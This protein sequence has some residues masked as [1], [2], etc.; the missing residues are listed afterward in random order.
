MFVCSEVVVVLPVMPV[1]ARGPLEGVVMEQLAAWLAAE[2]YSRTMVPQV[3]G[4]AR[5]LSAWMDDH[6][7]S[8]AALSLDVLEAFQAKYAPGVP[9]HVIVKVR[10]PAVRRFLVECGYLPGEEWYV[11]EFVARA[12]GRR[13][14]WGQPLWASW[15]RGAVGSARLAGSARHVSIIVGAGL[16]HWSTHCP[17]PMK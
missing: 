14:R 15:M 4:V 1:V 17:L 2:R 16:A 9:G 12:R 6:D 5:G 11:S 7:V 3:L 8:L 13:R 10:S